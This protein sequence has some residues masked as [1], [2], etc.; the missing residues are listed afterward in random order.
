MQT[1][2][3]YVANLATKDGPLAVTATNDAEKAKGYA[4]SLAGY[5]LDR[6]TGRLYVPPI[7]AWIDADVADDPAMARL[8]A[9]AQAPP[10]CGCTDDRQCDGCLDRIAAEGGQ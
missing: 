3:R 5:V 9:G 2:R 7:G 1:Q 8:L 6:R 4:R 10:P